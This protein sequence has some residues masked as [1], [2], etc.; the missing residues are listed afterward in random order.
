MVRM[1][2][3]KIIVRSDWVWYLCM[4]KR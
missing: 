1:T 4:Q 3:L 2:K